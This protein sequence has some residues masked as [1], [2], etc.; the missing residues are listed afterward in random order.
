VQG[1][2]AFAFYGDFYAAE[3]SVTKEGLSGSPQSS[4]VKTVEVDLTG[5]PEQDIRKQC[6]KTGDA[7]ALLCQQ[8]DI[9]SAGANGP[10]CRDI[11]V[12]QKR[13]KYK[14]KKNA[15]AGTKPRSAKWKLGLTKGFIIKTCRALFDDFFCV[16][17]YS[18][19]PRL[20]IGWVQP[21]G[22]G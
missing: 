18:T 21:R 14:R 3:R 19:Q 13:A 11:L 20:P 9:I 16:P 8:V 15:P 12:R 6:E 10:R 2:P 17:P 4:V 22:A 5:F 1:P 7:A